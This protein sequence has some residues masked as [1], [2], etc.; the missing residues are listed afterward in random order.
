M[1]LEIKFI[2]EKKVKEVDSMFIFSI[3]LIISV[4]IEGIIIGFLLDSEFWAF[5]CILGVLLLTIILTNFISR[6][7]IKR[8]E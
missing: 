7:K 5:A 2:E 6:I 3:L 8:L 4:F 1:K